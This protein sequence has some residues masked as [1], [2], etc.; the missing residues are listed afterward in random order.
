VAVLEMP[1]SGRSGAGQLRGHFLNHWLLSYDAGFIRRGLI[2]TLTQWSGLT[3]HLVWIHALTIG[4]AVWLIVLTQRRLAQL[5]PDGLPG[6]AVRVSVTLSPLTAVWIATFGDVLHVCLILTLVALPWLVRLPPLV[7]LSVA[8]PLVAVSMLIH[9]ASASLIA[10]AV[11]LVFVTRQRWGSALA[12]AAVTF[13]G[14]MLISTYGQIDQA[15]RDVLLPT[16]TASWGPGGR[17]YSALPDAFVFW[18]FRELLADEDFRVSVRLGWLYRAGLVPLLL[19]V[20]WGMVD[21]RTALRVGLWWLALLLCAAPLFVIG[22]DWGRFAAYLWL[23]A[24]AC[25][26]LPRVRFPNETGGRSQN[27][28]PNGPD[29]PGLVLVTGVLLA[30]QPI[31]PLYFISGLHPSSAWASAVLLPAAYWWWTRSPSR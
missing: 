2:G 11:M 7:S 28:T 19:T 17:T 27:A 15:T 16:M 14:V 30:I 1:W 20:L 18:S 8:I 31:T 23:L 24:V 10:P 9:E 22:H 26:A 6:F 21:R 5:L 13:A 4:L 3:S 12:V 25:V 29:I